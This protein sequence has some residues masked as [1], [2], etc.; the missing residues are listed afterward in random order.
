MH[1]VGFSRL[2][3]NTHPGLRIVVSGAIGWVV[4]LLLPENL[5]IAR[6]GGAGWIVAV[7][8]ILL[9][10]SAAVGSATPERL[11]ALARIND[12]SRWLIQIL[13]VLAAV[14]S[15]AEAAALLGKEPTETAAGLALRVLLAGGV[16]VASWTLIHFIFAVHYMHGYYGDDPTD[17]GTGGDAGGLAFPGDDPAPDFWDFVYFSL[18]IGMTCQVS[19]VQITSRRMRRIATVHGALSFFFNTVILALTIN[20]LVNSV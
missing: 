19:D 5:G 16:V 11:R 12:P 13:V 2:I 9:L 10:L 1:I 3:S 4:F 18:V 6:R 7:A 8:V 15:L 17:D 20:F 14:A